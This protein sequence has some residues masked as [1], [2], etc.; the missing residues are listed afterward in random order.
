[1]NEQL[2][3]P[4]GVPEDW[5][6]MPSDKGDGREYVNPRK[7]ND[8]IRVMPGDPNDPFPA[9]RA[10]YVIDQNGGFRDVNGNVIRGRKP[11]AT[12]E[13]HIPLERFKFRR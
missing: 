5:I 6:E 12:A 11:G 3:K 1:M 8:R 4:E 9:R 7:R 2:P 10:P 13:A